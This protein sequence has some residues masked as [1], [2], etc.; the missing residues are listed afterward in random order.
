MVVVVVVVVNMMMMTVM[1]IINYS[2]AFSSYLATCPITAFKC[3]RIALYSSLLDF[4]S[5]S[6]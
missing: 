3:K 5:W 4:T 2:H 1:L 6:K